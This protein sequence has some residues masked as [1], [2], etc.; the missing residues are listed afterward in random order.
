MNHLGH[1]TPIRSG[2]TSF[3]SVRVLPSPQSAARV[4]G[5]RLV[6]VSVACWAISPIIGFEAA[7]L[8]VTV[9]GFVVGVVGLRRPVLGLL[10]VGML[11][12][13]EPM[14]Q[15]YLQKGGLWRW[16]SFNYLLLIAIVLAVPQLLRMHDIQSRLLM[17][18]ILLLGLEVAISPN[19]ETG[20]QNWLDLVVV[21][22]F[23]VYFRKGAVGPDAWYWLGVLTGTSSAL[24]TLT[25]Y[26]QQSTMDYI[27]PNSMAVSPLAGLLAVCLGV[28]FTGNRLRERAAL[29]VLA[30]LNFAL[31]FLSGSRGGLAIACVGVLFLLAWMRLS[32]RLVLLVAA[33]L[34]VGFVAAI[35]FGAQEERTVG[36]LETLFDPSKSITTRTSGRFNLAVGGWYI[37]KSNPLGVGTGGFAANYA[38]L[39]NREGLGRFKEG[40]EM[41]AHSEWVKI[42]AEN[43]IPGAVLLGLFV[44]SFAASGW[45]RRQQ[46]LFPLGILVTVTLGVGFLSRELQDESLRLLV[47]GVMTLFQRSSAVR[48]S[49]RRV[50]PFRQTPSDKRLLGYGRAPARSAP[51]F[52][53]G[54]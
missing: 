36:R 33:V 2:P 41:A 32:L 9:I 40:K 34:L 7:L 28:L 52:M 44:V 25:L 31:I 21:L 54:N 26:L 22:G 6:L 10:G 47:A 8:V 3:T 1:E 11:C 18:M 13:L 16:N 50:P 30:S 39:G 48:G 46:G 53:P 49:R 5:A 23:L 37:F 45:S 14:A 17:L 12:A 24:A 42:L 43:G 51:I 15:V 27:N 35:R 4:W 20:M 38:H 29:L 19:P